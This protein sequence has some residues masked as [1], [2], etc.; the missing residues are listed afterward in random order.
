MEKK[1]DEKEK[2]QKP[3]R[4]SGKKYLSGYI[5]K[6]PDDRAD[7]IALILRHANLDISGES[8]EDTQ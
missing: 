5:Q 1:S 6:L 7:E 4:G 2:F 3:L 8:E